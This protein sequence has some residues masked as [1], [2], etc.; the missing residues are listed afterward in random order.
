MIR[1]YFADTFYWIALA[2]P[3]DAWHSPVLAW[4]ATRP[5]ARFVTTEEVLAE[6]LNWF[7]GSGPIGRNHAATVVR[8]IVIDPSTRVL[9]QTT[10]DFTAALALYEARPDKGD[11]LIDCRSMLS[12]RDLG[13]TEVLT[14]D[15]HPGRFHD[16]VPR[17]MNERRGAGSAGPVR[18]LLG[19]KDL[20]G[21]FY[22]S[23]FNRRSGSCRGRDTW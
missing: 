15:L 1:E 11:S 8:M 2:E 22:L 12:L 4:Q 16:L 5:S 20:T 18:S 19:G 13:V 23:A 21:R 6:F 3:K 9:V 17:P 7:A 14:H 10:A